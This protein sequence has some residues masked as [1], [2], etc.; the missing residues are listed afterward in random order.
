MTDVWT[1]PTDVVAGAAD[2]DVY[3][4]ETLANIRYLD[5]QDRARGILAYDTWDFSE[6]PHSVTGDTDMALN[7]VVIADATRA[8][9][10]YINTTMSFSA[11]GLGWTLDGYANGVRFGRWVFETDDWHTSGGIL[12]L[13]SAGGTYDLTVK[14]VEISGAVTMACAANA[15][16]IIRQMWVEDIGPR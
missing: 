8:Y 3:N 1:T 13:P 16:G 6:T 11:A 4:A 2:V 12:W 14:A 15:S 9:F 10:V 5:Q 7:D